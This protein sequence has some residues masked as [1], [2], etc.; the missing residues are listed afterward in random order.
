M[1]DDFEQVT[2]VELA[3]AV[4][5]GIVALDDELSDSQMDRLPHREASAL[6]MRLKG[7]YCEVEGCPNERMRSY[8][9]CP[10]HRYADLTSTEPSDGE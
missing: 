1:A 3:R 5:L 2:D 7:P 10:Q 4:Y 8:P 6:W 9:W